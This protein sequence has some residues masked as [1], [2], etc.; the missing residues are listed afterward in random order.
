MLELTRPARARTR[1]S[2][3]GGASLL[4]VLGLLQVA[5]GGDDAP[6]AAGAKDL[7]A[8]S[9]VQPAEDL[10]PSPRD[11]AAPQDQGAARDQG[12]RPDGAPPADLALDATL[13][14]GAPQDSGPADLGAAA[15]LAPVPDLA[16]GDG[17][18]P[19]AGGLPADP[20]PIWFLH[21][22]D[23]H[24]GEAPEMG[25]RFAAVLDEVAPVIGPLAILHTGDL[26]DLGGDAQQWVDYRAVVD[27]RT[28]DYP[29]YL[30]IPG[31]HDVKEG[32]E[33]SYLADGHTA[34]AVGGLYGE[35]WLDSPA[36]P[37]RIVRT[38]TADTTLNPANVVGYFG[39]DQAAALMALPVPA[40]RPALTLLLAHHP[41]TGVQRLLLLGSD[42]R[43]LRLIDRV[44]AD[45]Y[46]CGH[47]HMPYLSWLEDT[48]SIQGGS[49]TKP[50]L[51]SRSVALLAFDRGVLSARTLQLGDD[52]A[53][54]LSWPLVQVTYP[55]NTLLGGDNPKAT[56]LPEG[57]EIEVRALVFGAEPADVVQVRL[58]F[59]DPVAL[60]PGPG[61]LWTG[62]LP[63]ASP[64]LH[65][66]EVTAARGQQ[67][68]VDRIAIRSAEP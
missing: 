17:G 56:P 1:P 4:L 11:L 6:G 38:H 23:T 43:M 33:A 45:V 30:E 16:H 35:T 21:V 34:R 47:T 15:D 7:G 63:A 24:V 40:Q 18:A 64:G 65:Q 54:P 10:G 26:V 68:G 66:I 52:D 25:Q 19:D 32:G 42:L 61:P 5:C 9:D 3:S 62:T 31:N 27:G 67:T 49:T 2:A 22:T 8:R 53:Q 46:L 12:A 50:V 39:E 44:D 59:D 13:D 58:D 55:A 51:G 60:S 37:V 57:E 48:L 29:T 14:A 28:P 36:G 20:P 41:M